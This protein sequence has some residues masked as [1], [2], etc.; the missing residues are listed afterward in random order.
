MNRKNCSS[1]FKSMS[2]AYHSALKKFLRLP[3]FYSDHFTCGLF[4]AIPFE[5]F[6]NFKCI[7]F[8]FWL[9]TNNGLCFT[10]YKF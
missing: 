9:F 2:V 8:I 3:K 5:N 4:N 7:K 6:I 10:R 1:N